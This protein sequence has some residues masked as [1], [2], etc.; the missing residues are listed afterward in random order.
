[1]HLHL[2]IRSFQAQRTSVLTIFM[3]FWKRNV[4]LFILFNIVEKQV[5]TNS[6]LSLDIYHMARVK[7]QLVI[8]ESP[9]PQETWGPIPPCHSLAV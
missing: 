1:M 2:V 7:N 6:I 5:G 3:Q 4:F 8:Q 9:G